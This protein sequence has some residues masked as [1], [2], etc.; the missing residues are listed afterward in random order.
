MISQYNKAILN[1]DRNALLA[2]RE[3]IFPTKLYRYRSF[4][5][6]W[7][8][9]IIKGKV[10][11]GSP[12]NFN[13]P[14]DGNL[15]GYA[16]SFYHEVANSYTPI[17]LTDFQIINATGITKSFSEELKHRINGFKDCYRVA[18]FSERLDLMTMWA[19]YAAN[20]TGYVIEYDLSKIA[21]FQKEILY[22]VAYFSKEDINKADFSIPRFPIFNLLQKDVEWSYEQEWRMVKTR[23]SSD[24]EDLSECI[25]AVYLGMD[26][27]KTH[28]PDE[29]AVIQGHLQK[30]GAELREMCLS[31][32]GDS[33]ISRNINL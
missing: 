13:D 29:L 4:D 18:C 2:I 12:I 16:N 3:T 14:F 22:K 5:A 10:Y 25:S 27:K 6:H 11:M 17:P 31:A 20:H 26:F 23:D 30:T 28:Y 21:K 33:L 15:Y 1:G 9:N 32:A 7:Y 24:Y 8:S 19:H